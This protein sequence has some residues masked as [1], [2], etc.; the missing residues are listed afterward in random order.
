MEGRGPTVRIKCEGAGEEGGGDKSPI[1]Q[2]SCWS[3]RFGF[4]S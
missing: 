3:G 1:L 2:E 4:E